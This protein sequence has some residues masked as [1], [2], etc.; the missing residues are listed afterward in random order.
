MTPPFRLALVFVL[1][2]VAPILFQPV[3][4]RAGSLHLSPIILSLDPKAPVGLLTLENQGPAVMML[5][6]NA[7]S[8]T[9]E[10]GGQQLQDAPALVVTPATLVLKPGERRTL[11][12]GFLSPPATP[13]GAEIAYRLEIAEIPAE[14]PGQAV[15]L[16][17][18]FS[19]PLFYGPSPEAAPKLVARLQRQRDDRLILETANPGQR[20]LR[21]VGLRLGDSKTVLP[22]AQGLPSYVLAGSRLAQ[23]VAAQAAAKISLSASS[24]ALGGRATLLYSVPGSPGIREQEITVVDDTLHIARQ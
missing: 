17:M 12:A 5:E 11:R 1:C 6:V 24:V 15:R 19:V 7:R 4:A 21:L 13:N 8:W 18:Q 22:L 3:A 16:R 10:N 20:H 14:T 9:Q 23:P 2:L